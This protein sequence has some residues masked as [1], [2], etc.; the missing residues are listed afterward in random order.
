MGDLKQK[1]DAH[2]LLR[3]CSTF[4]AAARIEAIQTVSKSGVNHLPYDFAPLF[5]TARILIIEFVG[6]KSAW[7]F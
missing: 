5:S 2:H 7:I 4:G 3:F 6:I 1:R